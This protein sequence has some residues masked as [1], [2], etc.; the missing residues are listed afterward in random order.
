MGK[1][2]DFDRLPRDYYRTFDFKAVAPL[3]PHLVPQ[4]YFIEPCAG[5]GVLRDHLEA[6]GHV[7]VAAYD[8]EPQSDS[9]KRADALTHRPEQVGFT[10]ITN[11]P[12][13]ASLLNP[14]IVALS[15]VAPTWLLLPATWKENKSAGPYLSRLRKIVAIGRV[16]WIEGTKTAGKDDSN[17]YLFTQPQPDMPP[18]FYGRG[19]SSHA[20]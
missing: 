16:C 3:L 5:D 2:S 6:Q 15:D 20:A 19:Y 4:T 7:C 1:R 11:P 14:L 17:W 8:L 12:F 9:V 18:L 13:K 10:Y